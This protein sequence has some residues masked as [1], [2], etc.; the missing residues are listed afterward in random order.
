MVSLIELLL[1]LLLLMLLVLYAAKI[2]IKAEK[3][4][5]KVKNIV[6]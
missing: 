4:L 1:H 6:K 2:G 3:E 5:L